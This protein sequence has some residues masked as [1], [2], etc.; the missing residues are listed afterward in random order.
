MD[1]GCALWHQAN[2]P[3]RWLYWIFRRNNKRI[4]SHS[5]TYVVDLNVV[6]VVVYIISLIF[7]FLFWFVCVLFFSLV[8][9]CCFFHVSICQFRMFLHLFLNCKIY[10][11]STGVCTYAKFAVPLICFKFVHIFEIWSELVCQ[12][13]CVYGYESHLLNK[14]F[15]ICKSSFHS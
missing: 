3:N 13:T 12:S 15:S 5:L 9:I 14:A 2:K 10:I 6:P 1:F 7:F 8:F 4:Y 11:Y